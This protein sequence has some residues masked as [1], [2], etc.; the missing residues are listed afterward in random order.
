VPFL[1]PLAAVV[2]L[3]QQPETLSLLEEPLYAP[4]VPKAERARLEAELAE[5]SA[6]VGRDPANAAA[7]LRLANAQRGLGRIGDALE[8]LTRAVEG[9][10]ATP[11]VRVARGHGL[12]A[13][14]KFE[15][16]QR[17][18][19]KAAETRPDARCDVGFTLYLQADYKQ[20]LDEY[21]R[22]AADPG[23]FKYLAARRAGVDAGARPAPAADPG[24]ASKDVKFP[25]AVPT[26]PARQDTSVAATYMNAVDRLIAGDTAGAKDLLKSIV[27]KRKTMW[28]EPV[29]VAAESDYARILKD[30]PK[31]KKKKK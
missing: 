3:A 26:K 23:P 13:I 9:K 16:A 31:K 5:A 21:G 12:I 11:E 17:E 14:R 29:Y 18:F 7:V 22:C 1:L 6:E 8:T 27:E 24:R 4:P 30:E 15:L 10:A 25:G 2:F 19:R 20:A 28:M